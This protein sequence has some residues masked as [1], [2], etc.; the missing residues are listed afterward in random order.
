M[1]WSI[2]FLIDFDFDYKLFNIGSD[3]IKFKSD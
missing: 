1:L 2:R 3:Q